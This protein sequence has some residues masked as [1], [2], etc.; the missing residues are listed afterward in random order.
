MDNPNGN[1]PEIVFIKA[2]QAIVHDRF[3]PEFIECALF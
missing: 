1:F 3:L 2:E